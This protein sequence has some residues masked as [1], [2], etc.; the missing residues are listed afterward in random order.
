MLTIATYKW[1]VSHVPSV[2]HAMPRAYG[3]DHVNKWARG[4]SRN[5]DMEHRLILFTDDAEGVDPSVTCL[6]IPQAHLVEKGGCFVRL[7]VFSDEAKDVLGERFVVMDLDGVIVGPLDPLFDRDDDFVIWHPGGR[8]RPTPFCASMWMLRA[9]SRTR[10]WDRFDEKDLEWRPLDGRPGQ[11]LCNAHAH[12]AGYTVG[13]DQS[14]MSY[15]LWNGP[16]P[17]GLWTPK[18]GVHNYTRLPNPDKL[19]DGSRIVFFPGPRDP[20]MFHHSWLKEHWQ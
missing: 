11:W 10:V 2:I 9:G 19:P 7:W 17:F 6:P 12:D 5:L 8:N 18:D 1:D 14:W 13:G 15:C 16:E 3:A 4:V 20:S